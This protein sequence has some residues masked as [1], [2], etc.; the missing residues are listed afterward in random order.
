MA[1][2]NDPYSQN[3]I[4]PAQRGKQILGPNDGNAFDVFAPP[5]TVECAHDQQAAPDSLYSAPLDN[6]ATNRL[7]AP[8]TVDR[9]EDYRAP[10]ETKPDNILY[11]Y[12]HR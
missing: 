9:Q 4:T 5:E 3:T 10:R 11:D 2:V 7:S 1:N 8:P 6:D 12:G